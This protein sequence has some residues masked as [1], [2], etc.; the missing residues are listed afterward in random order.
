MR[1]FRDVN[2]LFSASNSASNIARLIQLLFERGTAVSSDFAVEEA[3]RNIELKRPAWTE[4]FQQLATRIEIVPSVQFAL[5]VELAEKDTP[6]LCTSIQ[7]TCQAL[8]TGDK[9]H[10]G[11]LYG[12]TI[13]GVRIVSLLQLADMLTSPRE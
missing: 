4:D 7:A 2:V 9:R 1:V 3:R 8:V 13:N 10:F 11:H 5:P 12:Q 6:I